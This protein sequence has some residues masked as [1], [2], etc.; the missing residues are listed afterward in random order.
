MN[1]SLHT[2]RKTYIQLLNEDRQIFLP[3][4]LGRL[5]LQISQLTSLHTHFIRKMSTRGRCLK[6]IIF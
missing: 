1:L 2:N 3:Q 5:L 6:W 4:I